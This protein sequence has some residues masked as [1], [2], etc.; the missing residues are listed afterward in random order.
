[1]KYNLDDKLK[2]GPLLLYALQWLAV[3]LP[4]VVTIGLVVGKTHYPG[5]VPAQHFYMQKLFFVLGFVSLVQILFG[6]RL[7]LVIGPASVLLIGIL[8]SSSASIPAIYTAVLIGGVFLSL[9]SVSGLLAHLRK[10]FTPRVVIVVMLLIPLT[11]APTIVR[12]VFVNENSALFNL[13]FALFITLA[14][15]IMNNLLKGVWKATTLIIGI[16][17]STILFALFN[18]GQI[19]IESVGVASSGGQ[20]L[21]TGFEFDAGLVVSFLFCAIALMVNE[22]GSIEAVGHILSA[23]NLDKRNKWGNLVLGLG[24]I[25]AGSLGVIG[26]VDFS[27]SPGIIASSR[28]AS[29]YPF[30]PVSLMMILLAFVPGFIGLLSAIPNIVMGVALIY[31][32]TS[33]FAAGLQMTVK[34]NAVLTFNDGAAIGASLMIALLVSFLPGGLTEQIPLFLRPIVGNGFVMGILVMLVMEHLIFRKGANET[35]EG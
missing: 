13:L 32:M 21:F 6:H 4:A 20:S 26:P 23:G 31:V 25:L 2:P 11:L 34:S 30:I 7:P 14:L 8:A 28:C 16:I 17:L 35:K 3:V 29:R 19:G 24:N 22:V 15:F 12:L 10:V 1:M 33:Q 5:E 9:I 18:P 27:S